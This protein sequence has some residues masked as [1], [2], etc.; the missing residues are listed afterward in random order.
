LVRHGETA[1]NVENRYTGRLDVPLTP[2]GVE[3]AQRVANYIAAHYHPQ[4]LYTSPLIRALETSRIIGG[5][6]ALTPQVVDELKERGLGELE[7]MA[8]GELVGEIDWNGALP[9]GG[10]AAPV[11]RARVLEAMQAILQKHYDQTV[12]VVSHGGPLAVFLAHL[13]DGQGKAWE[14]YMMDNG[15]LSVVN[16]ASGR[17]LDFR[18]NDSS[19]LNTHTRV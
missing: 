7:G 19:L 9:G 12:V 11:F 2:R 18:F 14:R 17:L 3:Q 6:C 16:M 13:I 4:A 1:H 10:E 8:R 5:V 15:A